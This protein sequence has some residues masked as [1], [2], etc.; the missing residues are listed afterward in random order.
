MTKHNALILA[1]LALI[2]AV[3]A[4]T[5]WNLSVA[6]GVAEATTYRTVTCAKGSDSQL[7][8]ELVAMGRTS[9]PFAKA[10]ARKFVRDLPATPP[11]TLRVWSPVTHRTY[12]VRRDSYEHR[13]GY[14]T[15]VYV[16][17]GEIAV[18]V[19]ARW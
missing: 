3:L 8:A 14:L 15:V 16:G 9:C 10:V 19:I 17:R 6:V 12:T 1:R 4:A 18:Q 2:A 11:R 5:L 13:A 7:S